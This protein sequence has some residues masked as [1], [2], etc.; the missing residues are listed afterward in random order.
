MGRVTI[1]TH[2]FDLPDDDAR[3]LGQAA[4][5]VGKRGGFICP[6]PNLM[7][8]I[9]TATEVSVEIEGDFKDMPT[10]AETLKQL[11]AK[12]GLTIL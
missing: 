7:L 6:A 12:R 5:A 11:S 10:P 3:T 2:T 8:R 9:G 1:G 4:I